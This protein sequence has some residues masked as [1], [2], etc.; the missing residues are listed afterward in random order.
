MRKI[1]GA[2]ICFICIALGFIGNSS[3]NNIDLQSWDLSDN[4]NIS[5]V[6]VRESLNSKLALL[7]DIL[8]DDHNKFTCTKCGAS[9][10][11]CFKFQSEGE[12]DNIDLEL[13]VY[14]PKF[15]KLEY[16]DPNFPKENIFV[17][18]NHQNDIC[19]GGVRATCCSGYNQS[20]KTYG[21][22][23]VSGDIEFSVLRMTYS[24]PIVSDVPKKTFQQRHRFNNC[25][26]SSQ[27]S[28]TTISLTETIYDSVSF[29]KS[30]SDSETLTLNLSAGVDFGIVRG[31]TSVNRAVTTAVTTNQGK[32]HSKG[33]TVTVSTV[34]N[35]NAPA[36]GT[37][38]IVGTT[39]LW[40]GHVN[41]VADIEA[42]AAIGNNVAGHKM[43]SEFLSKAER[44]YQIEGRL[45]LSIMSDVETNATE[46]QLSGPCSAAD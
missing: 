41:F 46:E 33:E 2:V 36:G 12:V 24:E 39:N 18:T 26:S 7:P 34:T 44:T 31:G 27:S 28:S 23:R 6:N 37:T 40:E 25:A 29:A 30:I 4:T 10:L 32:T 15:F 43:A 1:F 45:T 8:I 9:Q 22:P 17:K 11:E 19:G 20:I 35:V 3:A 42:D 21:K 16:R 5:L 14:S 38:V 13:P